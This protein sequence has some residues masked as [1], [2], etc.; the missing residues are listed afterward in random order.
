[1]NQ[2]RIPV[3]RRGVRSGI[4]VLYP[5]KRMMMNSACDTG[6]VPW[7]FGLGAARLFIL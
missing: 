2:A 1:M 6:R 7:G 4:Q 3:V 5:S